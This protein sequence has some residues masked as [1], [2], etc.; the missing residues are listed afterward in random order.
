V[1]RTEKLE[2]I[3]ELRYQR[4]EAISQAA[5][6]TW[7]GMGAAPVFGEEFRYL[8]RLAAQCGYEGT[9]LRDELVKEMAGGQVN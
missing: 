9:A 8:I 2:R 7:N 1:I 3:E 5:R 4:S 6:S